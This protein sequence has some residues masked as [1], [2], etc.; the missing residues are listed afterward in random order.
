MRMRRSAG[1]RLHAPLR[2]DAVVPQPTTQRRPG[3]TVSYSACSEPAG[4]VRY[5]L[6]ARPLTRLL[7]NGKSTIARNDRDRATRDR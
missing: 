6:D 4:A 7:E 2:R 1:A 5:L 3:A